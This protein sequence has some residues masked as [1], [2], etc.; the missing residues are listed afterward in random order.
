MASDTSQNVARMFQ[1]IAR[2]PDVVPS[3]VLAKHRVVGTVYP[4][5]RL[6]NWFPTSAPFWALKLQAGIRALYNHG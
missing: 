6:A 4:A 1:S 5:H 3:H 2:I